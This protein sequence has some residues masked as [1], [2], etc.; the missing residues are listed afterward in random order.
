MV[1]AVAPEYVSNIH[2]ARRLAEMNGI[3]A[4][5]QNVG[6]TKDLKQDPINDPADIVDADQINQRMAEILNVPTECM[7]DGKTVEAIRS[8]RA[9]AANVAQTAEMLDKG[10]GAVNKIGNT[11][12]T[13]DRL[14]APLARAA[15]G[16]GA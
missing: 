16:L 13:E 15:T 11:P 2:Q 6:A 4:W 12:I 7:K 3:Q 1:R 14:L 8:K 10:A 9:D 5:L